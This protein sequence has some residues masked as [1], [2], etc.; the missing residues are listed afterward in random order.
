MLAFAKELAPL[1]IKVDAVDPG[2]TATDSNN[3]SGYR[4]VEQAAAGM[5]WLATEHSAGQSGR[6][7]FEQNQVAS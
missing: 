1:S 6:S 3:H 7:D 5:V 4:T 2:N